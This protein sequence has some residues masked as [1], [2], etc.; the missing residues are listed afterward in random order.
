MHEVGTGDS[1]LC[2]PAGQA[3]ASAPIAPA[4]PARSL[5]ACGTKPSLGRGIVY[6]RPEDNLIPSSSLLQTPEDSL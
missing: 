1:W 2:M 4:V 3:V 5:R 6:P